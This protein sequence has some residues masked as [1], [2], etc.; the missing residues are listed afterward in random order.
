VGIKLAHKN[1]VLDKTK[2]K[3]YY[4]KYIYKINVSINQIHFFRNTKLEIDFDARARWHKSINGDDETNYDLAMAFVKFRQEVTRL[5]KDFKII[6]NYNSIDV[7]ANDRAIFEELLDTIIATGVDLDDMFIKYLYAVPKANYNDRVIYHVE[8]KHN[9]RALLKTA[10]LSPTIK[11]DL[12][13]FI[14]Q[15][16]LKPSL[17]LDNHLTFNRGTQLYLWVWSHYFIDFDDEHMISLLLLRF[18]GL[19]RKVCKIEKR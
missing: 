5:Q 19:I 9:Y 10:K 4:D 2:I 6:I 11:R 8:P 13:D 12:A 3:L 1:F 15:Y 7:Y 18:D 17:S 16:G 14:T